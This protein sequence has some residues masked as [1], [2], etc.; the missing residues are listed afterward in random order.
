MKSRKHRIGIGLTNQIGEYSYEEV[1]FVQF[2]FDL[3][4]FPEYIQLIKK[5]LS[6]TK[7]TLTDNLHEQ[8]F[9]RYKRRKTG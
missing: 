3:S 2:Y 8:L 5:I 4:G 1:M 9:I 6:Y 7:G